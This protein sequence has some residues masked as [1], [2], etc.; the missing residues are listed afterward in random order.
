MYADETGD[1]DMSG[2]PGSSTYFGFGT[3]VFPDGHGEQLWQGHQLRCRLERAGLSLPRGMHAKNDSHATRQQ[4]FDVIAQQ[5]PRFDTT[6]LLKSAAYDSIK[7]AGEI[8]LYKM[9][10]YLHFTQIAVQVS[11]PGDTLYV[12]AATLGTHRKA[13]SARVALAEVCAQRATDREIVLCV[14]DAASTWGVQ[15]ADYGLWAVQRGL[16]GRPCTWLPTHIQP[17]LQSV[18]RPWGAAPAK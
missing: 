10:W 3:A 4:V 2:S 9:A 15:V 18:F 17:T 5:G 7:R 11:Q 16:E 13:T 6:F 12:I 14:W 1:L 8:R